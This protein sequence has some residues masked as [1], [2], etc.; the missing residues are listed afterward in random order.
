MGDFLQV[1][2]GIPRGF[3]TSENFFSE[4]VDFSCIFEPPYASLAPVSQGFIACKLLKTQ[5]LKLYFKFSEF[6]TALWKTL[7][8][9]SSKGSGERAKRKSLQYFAPFSQS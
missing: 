8:K 1:F 3:P 5:N 2:M 7:W 9:T 4:P 6:S